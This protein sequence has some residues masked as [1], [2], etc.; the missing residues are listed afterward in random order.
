LKYRRSFT[1]E[2]PLTLV[3]AF[4]LDAM[5]LKKLTPPPIVMQPRLIEP[6]AE[7]SVSQ[8][9]LWLGPLPVRWTAR[10]SQVGP[11]GFVDEQ[12]QGPFARWIHQH[13][14]QALGDG[15]SIITD[16]I[17]AELASQPFQWLIGAGM[18]L[19]LPI[20]FAYRAWRTRKELARLVSKGV[21]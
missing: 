11:Q 17:E 16:A 10:H 1:V 21:G 9:V 19:G 2:A 15:R 3:A 6:L 7:N 5:A 8:F 18:W 4:H 12:E 13:R 20:L 14:Y